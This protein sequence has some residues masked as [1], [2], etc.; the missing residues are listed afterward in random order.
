VSLAQ[1]LFTVRYFVPETRN[2][3]LEEIEEFWTGTT[4]GA[5]ETSGA[6]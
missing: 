2:R 3:P 6:R 4:A 5:G 1:A